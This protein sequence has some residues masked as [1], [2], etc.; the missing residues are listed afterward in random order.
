MRGAPQLGLSA[1]MRRINC[2]IS[3]LTFGRPGLPKLERNRQ[4]SRNPAVLDRKTGWSCEHSVTVILANPE[5]VKARKGHKTDPQDSWWLAHLLRHAMIV[6][7]LSLHKPFE[8]C[9]I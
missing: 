7:V 8:S 2:R 3:P 5:D 1:F 6:R 9:V 4:N